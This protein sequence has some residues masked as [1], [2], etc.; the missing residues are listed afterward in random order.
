MGR[1]QR[2]LLERAGEL[3]ALEVAFAA[4]AAGSGSVVLLSGEAGIGKTSVVREF[5]RRVTGRGRLLLGACED[6]LAPRTFGPLRDIAMTTR[7]GRLA[8]ALESADPEAVLAAVEAELADHPG[9]SVLVVEDAHWADEATVDVLRYLSRRIERLFA[10]LVITYRV[11]EIGRVHPLYRVTGSLSGPGVLRLA[12]GPLSREAVTR[13]AGGTNATSARLYALTGGNP[14]FLSEVLA[15]PDGAVPGTVVD[16][17]LSRVRRLALPVT[18]ALEQLAVVPAG[19]ELTL[20]R[21]LLADLTVLAEAER[22]GLVEVRP[23]AVGFRHELARR[24]VE[25]ALPVTERMR[26][27]QTVLD[28]LLADGRADLARVVH[29]AVGAGD[30]AAVAAHAPEAARRACRAGAQGQGA[31]LFEQARQRSELLASAERVAVHAELG[32][33]LYNLGRPDAAVQA[34]T[35]AV[36]L[37]ESLGD[38]ALGRALVSA[39]LHRWAALDPGAALDSGER[40]EQLLTSEVDPAGHALALT[41]LGALRVLQDDLHGGLPALESGIAAAS[42]IQAGDLVALGLLYRGR[43]RL[44]AGDDGGLDDLLAAIDRAAAAG[45]HEL[46]MR[47]YVNLVETLWNRGRRDEVG[48]QITAATRYA[49]DREYRLHMA[50]LDAYRYRWLAERGHWDTA[51]AG[52]RELVGD[53]ADTRPARRHC[54]AALAELLVRRGAGDA[55]SVLA[56]AQRHA[57]RADSLTTLVPAVL[58]R[59]ELVRWSGAAGDLGTADLLPRLSGPGWAWQR[60]AVLVAVQRTGASAEPP[61]GCPDPFAAGVRGDWAAAAAAWERIGDPYQRALCLLDSGVAEPTL[62]ALAVLDELGARPAAAFARLRLRAMGV[63]RIPRG[64]QPATRGN[65]AG[66]TGRQVEILAA[67]AEG[68]TNAEIAARLVISVRTVDHHVSAVLQKLGATS[69]R[70]AISAAAL[71]TD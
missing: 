15:T 21:R 9:P 49:G 14:F 5:A 12:L 59:C 64:P 44:H 27:H 19:I 62:D 17:V 38:G 70:E 2:P 33:A 36:A 68:L 8:G 55:P 48:Q 50:V 51:E 24:A 13:W 57:R 58:A 25:G 34:S 29:H 20:A 23:T 53:L 4:A 71:F 6:L 47:A 40:A 7:S 22:V 16:A 56:A 63:S 66:L 54:L 61:D 42:E 52:L 65:P 35:T 28:A 26:L 31:A 39:S 37:A 3:T 30:D 43:G 11:G 1:M 67:L 41:Q 45:L 69:R 18:R 32:W 46:V 10:V 60:G